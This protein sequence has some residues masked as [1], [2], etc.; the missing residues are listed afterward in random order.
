LVRRILLTCAPSLALALAA[1]LPA[2]ADPGN[3]TCPV[4]GAAIT[5][6]PN[7]PQELVNGS[8]VY[9][10]CND[11]VKMFRGEPEKYLLSLDLAKC[12]VLGNPARPDAKL[13][14]VV[15]NRLYYFCCDSCPAAFAKDPAKYVRELADPV[16]K[17]SFSMTGASPHEEYRGQRYFFAGADSKAKFDAAPEQYV[18]MFGEKSP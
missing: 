6:G 16:T 14:V 11:C 3:T 4:T 5:P 18:T 9:F 12:P 8:P 7:A 17:K 2:A 10:C 13:R 1:T 15:N